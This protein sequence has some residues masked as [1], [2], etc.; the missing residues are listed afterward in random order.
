MG[1]K[2]V[3]LW[4][5]AGLENA[6]AARAALGRLMHKYPDAEW[7]LFG[8]PGSLFLFEMDERVSAYIPLKSLQARR[9]SQ[10]WLSHYLAQR[11]QY[12][13]LGGLQLNACEGVAVSQPSPEDTKH[14]LNLLGRLSRSLGTRVCLWQESLDEFLQIPRPVLQAGPQALAFATH[15]H[16]TT[17]PNAVKHLIILDGTHSLPSL[18]SQLQGLQANLVSNQAVVH[19]TIAVLIENNR[20]TSR[21]LGRQQPNWLQVDTAQAM[22]LMAYSDRVLTPHRLLCFLCEE[23]GRVN[24]LMLVKSDI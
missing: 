4:F 2:R 10:G 23:M 5:G 18:Q 3:G 15:H 17:A 1:T 12:K 19:L 8:P 20:L 7:V 24:H 14:T 13:K 16:R 21:E 11:A 6:L 22:G 9:P